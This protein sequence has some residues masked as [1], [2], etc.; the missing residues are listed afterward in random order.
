[1]PPTV[2]CELL[3]L[4]LE[5][6]LK[7]SAW[8]NRLTSAVGTI[9]L[10][11]MLPALLSMKRYMPQRLDIARKQG[12]EG[13][14][15]ELARVESDGG[16]ISR[17]EIV[18]MLFMLLFAGHETTT[19]LISGSVRELLLLPDL[20]DWLMEDWTRAEA[21]GEEFLRFVSPVQFTKP[22]F[23]RKNMELG[24]IALKKG[25]L[26][27]PMLTA[28]NLDP[29]TNRSQRSLISNGSRIGTWPLG[30]IST[31]AS[32]INSLY[33]GS[34]RAKVVISAV[35]ESSAG[36]GRHKD[37]LAN[38]G[39]HAGSRSPA[40]SCRR[41]VAGSIALFRN[42]FEQEQIRRSSRR[43]EEIVIVTPSVAFDG[44]KLLLAPP[45][46]SILD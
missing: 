4:P 10:L 44:S 9:S 37:S 1:M 22:R 3:A 13:R 35:A 45:V 36:S 21:A 25:D 16:Q 28:A 34:V 31:F 15:A 39:R 23:V 26:I 12:G 17:N 40:D 19:H 29:N 5:D 24:G 2:V 6:R 38:S 33:R 8:A 43:F 11:S 20:R 7:V 41:L 32:A 42:R 18:S 30:R 27:M 46:M 14:I